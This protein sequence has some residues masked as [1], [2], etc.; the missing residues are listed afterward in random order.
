MRRS[1]MASAA[2]PGRDGRAHSLKADVRLLR[3]GRAGRNGGGR[4]FRG[5]CRPGAGPVAPGRTNGQGNGVGEAGLPC[6]PAS[7]WR[8]RTW[9]LSATTCTGFRC[10]QRQDL[11]GPGPGRRR[12]QPA[13]PRLRPFG[14]ESRQGRERGRARIRVRASPRHAVACHRPEAGAAR[15]PWDPC[16]RRTDLLQGSRRPAAAR[17]W[18]RGRSPRPDCVRPREPGWRLSPSGGRGAGF[19]FRVPLDMPGAMASARPAFADVP[20]VVMSPVGRAVTTRDR[21]P[22][23]PPPACATSLRPKGCSRA[24]PSCCAARSAAS[25]PS[26][27]CGTP[28]SPVL[29]PAASAEAERFGPGQR[30]AVALRLPR[31]RGRPGGPAP[32][33]HGHPFRA[34]CRCRDLH[35]LRAARDGV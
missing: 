35:P 33:G 30:P 2:R 9:G 15:R 17:A 12:A 25:S 18:R 3:P 8:F 20:T 4:V 32:A 27:S 1:Q 22:G 34:Q 28:G 5:P 26:S 24:G 31:P 14:V 6:M 11:A 13:A 23:M 7:G 16:L 19:A 29:V 10:H 21:P